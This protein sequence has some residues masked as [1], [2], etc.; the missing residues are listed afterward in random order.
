MM[1]KQREKGGLGQLP[2]GPR[3]QGRRLVELG[4]LGLTLACQQAS[5]GCGAVVTT[6]ASTQCD[7]SFVCVCPVC[8]CVCVCV[9]GF[10][11]ALM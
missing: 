2:Q 5:R 3:D 4:G 6:T 1:A 8:V 9:C 7:G 11:A 10:F